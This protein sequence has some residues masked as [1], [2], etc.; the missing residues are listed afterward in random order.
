MTFT[1][2]VR[3]LEQTL[4]T[5][6]ISLGLTRMRRMLAELGDPQKAFRIIHVAG[7]NGKGSVSAMLTS[8]LTHSGIR[9]GMYIS[10]HLSSVTERISIDTI[11]ITSRS[12]AALTSRL[13]PLFLRHGATYFEAL[14]VMALLHFKEQKVDLAVV[15]VGLGGRLDATNMCDAM[16]AI[17]TN[18]SLEHTDWLGHD[19]A[20]IANEKAGII[21]PGQRVL[22]GTLGVARQV[23]RRVAADKG[24]VLLSLPR[25]QRPKGGA[26]AI[27][28]HH[29]LHLGLRGKF[30][31]D[32]ARL[33]IGAIDWLRTQGF[34]IPP[35]NVR[36]GLEHVR[37]PGRMEQGTNILLDCAHNLTGAKA[38]AGEIRSSGKN[39]ILVIGILDDKDYQGM[40]RAFMGM[41]SLVILTAPQSIRAIMPSELEKLFIGKSI[42]HTIEK[43]IP[44]ALR[45]AYHE[46]N[47]QKKDTIILVTGSCYTVGEARTYLQKK[48][49]L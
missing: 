8:V 7:T 11:S 42:Q 33:V 46:L 29:D 40:I 41:S 15:E 18:I 48:G 2:A 5:T 12:F 25:I 20:S 21:K 30:Q 38:L 36:K 24:A 39:I 32:N 37:W 43:T 3:F 35:E 6:R 34:R 28:N 9:T 44:S 23:I 10:P 4:G 49:L 19:L 22:T 1:D 45:R 27:G 13:R 26:L 31:E 16:L 47:E 17:I 14:T